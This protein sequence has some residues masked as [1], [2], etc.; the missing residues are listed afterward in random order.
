MTFIIGVSSKKII[1][2]TD[3]YGT[4]EEKKS[5][6]ALVLLRFGRSDD[7]VKLECMSSKKKRCHK[8]SA[9]TTQKT[10]KRPINSIWKKQSASLLKSNANQ[11]QW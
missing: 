7:V 9:R 3:R 1:L 10:T 5:N 8:Y 11:Q 6:W 2:F 4:D